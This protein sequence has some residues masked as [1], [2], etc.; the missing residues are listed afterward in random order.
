MVENLTKPELL[1]IEKKRVKSAI[2][3]DFILSVEIII[4]TL[5]TVVQEPILTQILVVSIIALLAT[6]GVY[7]VVALIVRMDEVG[8]KLIKKSTKEKSFSKT[9]G[10]FLVQALPKVI[11]TLGVIGTIALM[12]VSGGIFVHNI[13]GLHHFLPNLPSLIL[14]FVVGLVVGMVCLA[15]VLGIKKLWGSGEGKI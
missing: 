7:G 13:E 10:S 5:G 9:L 14:E 8:Y 4:I 1:A 3:T 11:K 6:V 15:V 12:L 2:F